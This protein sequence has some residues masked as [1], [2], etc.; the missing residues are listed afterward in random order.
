M[1]KFSKSEVQSRP[2][3]NDPSI[4]YIYAV[5][6]PESGN[7]DVQTVEKA[8]AELCRTHGWES[9]IYRMSGEEDLAEVTRRAC[10]QGA[11]LVAAAGGDGTVAGVINGLVDSRIPLAIIPNGTGNGLARAMKIPLNL[12]EAVRLLAGGYAI[13]SI[14]AMRVNDKHYV[15]NVSAGISSRAMGGTSSK[16]KQKK[17]ILAY[18]ETILKDDSK[19]EARTFDLQIDGHRLRIEAVEVLVSN[20]RILKESPFLFGGRE[21]FSD[22]QLQVNILRANN[23][24]EFV[25]LAWDLILNGEEGNSKLNSLA[26]HQQIRM[27]TPRKP[28]PVQADGEVIG[29]TPVNINLV[30]KAVK[31]I[32][33][34]RS[35]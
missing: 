32:V 33:P 18:A 10:S 35:G 27:D 13:Q 16:E 28:M 22:G 4:Q 19:D 34:E 7:A 14:D 25:E 21:S 24:G 12:T 6:N 8:L 2:S 9:E 29:Q 20:G 15:L 1:R 11:T 31:V 23:L 26:I 30:P 5:V 17:G 3:Q